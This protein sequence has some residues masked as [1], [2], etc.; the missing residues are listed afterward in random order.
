M[1]AYAALF[2][3]LTVLSLCFVDSNIQPFVARIGRVSLAVFA[4]LFVV[5]EAIYLVS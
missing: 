4:V 5:A 3:V 2:G 1:K